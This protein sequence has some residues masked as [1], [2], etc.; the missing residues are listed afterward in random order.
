MSGRRV[1][2]GQRH[3]K[4]EAALDGLIA[5]LQ[6]REELIP[7]YRQQSDG[8]G[9]RG[10]GGAAAEAGGMH[11]SEATSEGLAAL[12]TLLLNGGWDRYWKD[13]QVLPLAE[14]A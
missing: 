6:T 1:G 11:W 7:N 10:A 2:R 14:A 8:E 12:R 4:D 13:R 5:Y 9:E 3:A